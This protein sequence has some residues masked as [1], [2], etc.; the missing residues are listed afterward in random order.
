M[1]KRRKYTV[2]YKWEIVAKL[3]IDGNTKTAA[4]NNLDSSMLRRWNREAIRE[5]NRVAR[6]EN[7]AVEAENGPPVAMAIVIPTSDPVQRKA[8]GQL[9]P[10][11]A[12]IRTL[13]KSTRNKCVG[14]APK[15]TPENHKRKKSTGKKKNQDFEAS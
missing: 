3:R 2:G 13:K 6:V 4:S 1:V 7:E 11:K 10:Q 15:R 5:E 14:K 12:T 8:R 9:R